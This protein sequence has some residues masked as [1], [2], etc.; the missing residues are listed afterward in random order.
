MADSPDSE[1]FE[2]VAES[3][4]E[5]DPSGQIQIR[6]H[7]DGK[8]DLIVVSSLFEDRDSSERE[9]VFWPALRN[10]PL[11]LLVHM[12]YSLMLTPEEARQ[13]FAEE[14]HG[15]GN[16]SPSIGGRGADSPSIGGRGA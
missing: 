6:K 15:E 13:F 9:A 1:L 7:A 10:L 2:R 4:R 8:A 3:W 11:D 5:I 12:T 14:T 16:D